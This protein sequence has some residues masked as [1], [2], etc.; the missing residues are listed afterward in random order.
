MTLLLLI[1]T[2]EKYWAFIQPLLRSARTYF[3]EH[4]VLLFTDHMKD[5]GVKWR[6]LRKDEGFPK[7][8]L[9][10]Y[11]TFAHLVP[12]CP[13]LGKYS[14]LFYCDIDM[15]FVNPVGDILS[16]GITATLHAGY[17][18]GV[19]GPYEKLTESMACTHNGIYYYCGGFVGGETKTFLHM[20]DYIAR[21]VTDDDVRG[22]TA[23]WN[24]ESHLNYYLSIYP[25]AKTL[26]PS[27]CYPSPPSKSCFSTRDYYYGI[28]GGKKYDPVLVCQR[29]VWKE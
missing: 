12:R 21:G 29:K 23:I 28:W 20:C 14:H 1:A 16:D 18:N 4:D 3:V 9:H 8:T 6:V 26:S 10:R 17:V 15:L 7:T 19:E 22:V 27:F 2:G 24:D 5:H 11:N 25:P 13:E